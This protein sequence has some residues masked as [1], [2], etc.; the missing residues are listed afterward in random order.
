MG[1]RIISA[2]DL[3]GAQDQLSNKIVI[4]GRLHYRASDEHLTPL[5]AMPGVLVHASE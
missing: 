1:F 2:S 4:I 3:P 5:G